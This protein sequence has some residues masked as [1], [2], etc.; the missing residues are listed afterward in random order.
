MITSEILR[1]ILTTATVRVGSVSTIIFDFHDIQ[2]SV[3]SFHRR[4]IIL[5]YFPQFVMRVDT[6]ADMAPPFSTLLR[7]HIPIFTH[8]SDVS[9]PDDVTEDIV[10]DGLT[11]MVMLL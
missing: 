3:T 4:N 5:F 10:L 8:I 6:T 11:K 2:I 7:D 9:F 1:K